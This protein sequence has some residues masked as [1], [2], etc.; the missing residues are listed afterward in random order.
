MVQCQHNWASIINFAEEEFKA[1][2][3][4]LGLVTKKINPR[5]AQAPAA[6]APD[7]VEEPGAGEEITLTDGAPAANPQ[8]ERISSKLCVS[9]PRV[10]ELASL[11][12]LD[13][14]AKKHESPSVSMEPSDGGGWC[15]CAECTKIGNPSERVVLLANSVATALEE[16]YPDKYVGILS[17]YLHA[18]PPV[19]KLHPRVVVSLATGLSGKMPLEDR[20]AGWGKVSENLGI[21]VYLSVVE[22]H[23]GL[24]AK[25]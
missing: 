3:E 21:H 5:V 14:F 15:E 24:P 6:L 8:Q 13:Y 12:A 11:Y 22:W 18:E 4:Y 1:H 20:L 23:L 7:E 10:R 9:N 19:R 17:Y 25:S 2:P 16:K